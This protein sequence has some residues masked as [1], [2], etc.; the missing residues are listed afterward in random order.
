[1]L[2]KAAKMAGPRRHACMHLQVHK[3]RPKRKKESQQ[4]AAKD[5]RVHPDIPHIKDDRMAQAPLSL[6]SL[7]GGHAPPD[8]FLGGRVS[9]TALAV[10]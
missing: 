6:R 5:G 4:P 8:F 7:G 2:V 1:M 9:V 10:L 3:C